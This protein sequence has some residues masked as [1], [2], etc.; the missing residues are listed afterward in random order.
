MDAFDLAEQNQRANALLQ[1]P[2]GRFDLLD[3]TQVNNNPDGRTEVVELPPAVERP[4]PSRMRIVQDARGNVVTQAGG[5]PFEKAEVRAQI[6]EAIRRGQDLTRLLERAREVGAYADQQTPD[7]VAPMREEPKTMVGGQRVGRLAW[8]RLR[9]QYRE[10]YP[11]AAMPVDLLDFDWFRLPP[12]ELQALKDAE[13][14]RVRWFHQY[15]PHYEVLLDPQKV[16]QLRQQF[17]ETYPGQ[18]VP[19]MF[20]GT[21]LEREQAQANAQM[22][23]LRM[24]VRPEFAQ[25]PD[26]A[27]LTAI[28][29]DPGRVLMP[30]QTVERTLLGELA[31]ALAR[32]NSRVFQT[33]LGGGSG[34]LGTAAEALGLKGAGRVLRDAET[35]FQS[36]Y[37]TRG[38]EAESLRPS[39]VATGFNPGSLRWWLA[40][41]GENA[42]QLVYTWGAGAA[43]RAGASSYQLTEKATRILTNATVFGTSAVQ[44]GGAAYNEIRQQLIA[45]GL[46]PETASQ[47]AAIAAAPVAVANGLLELLPFEQIVNNREANRKLFTLARRL[48]HAGGTEGATEVLQELNNIV[49]E[50]GAG[51]DAPTEQAILERLGTAGLIG[52]ALGGGA[53]ATM[54]AAERAPD[55]TAAAVRHGLE[56]GRNVAVEGI[57]GAGA[58]TG[59]VMRGIARA[60]TALRDVE[61]AGR[62]AVAAARPRVQETIENLVSRF[63]RE[64]TYR[65]AQTPGAATAAVDTMDVGA[66]LPP[67]YVPSQPPTAGERARRKALE[68]VRALMDEHAPRDASGRRRFPMAFLEAIQAGQ[69]EARRLLDQFRVEGITG[70]RRAQLIQKLNQIDKAYEVEIAAI[71]A[72]R[73]AQREG[74]PAPE[75]EGIGARRLPP[76]P[77]KLGEPKWK[78]KLS[79][80]TAAKSRAASRLGAG[81]TFGRTQQV[82]TNQILDVGDPNPANVR[83]WQRRLAPGPDSQADAVPPIVVRKLPNGGYQVLDGADQLAAAQFLE[84]DQVPVIVTEGAADPRASAGTAAVRRRITGTPPRRLMRADAAAMK[85]DLVKGVKPG[86]VIHGTDARNLQFIV[87]QGLQASA[88]SGSVD[89]EVVPEGGFGSEHPST[90]AAYAAGR[91]Q[92]LPILIVLD[93]RTNRGAPAQG[94]VNAVTATSPGKS[95]VAPEDIQAVIFPDGQRLPLQEALRYYR[96]TLLPRMQQALPE[97]NEEQPEGPARTQEAAPEESGASAGKS[98]RER[99]D[100]VD[101]SPPI[102]PNLPAEVLQAHGNTDTNAATAADLDELL[103]SVYDGRQLWEMSWSQLKTAGFSARRS[104]DEWVV[105]DPKGLRIMSARSMPGRPV[106]S[107][108]KALEVLREHF[109][110]AARN[111]GLYTPP[112]EKQAL[113]GRAALIETAG[114]EKVTATY[115][116][117]EA[118]D[119]L[120]SHDPVTFRPTPGYPAQLNERDYQNDKEEQAKVNRQV[121]EF[122]PAFVLTDNPDPVNGPPMI[123]AN[124]WV[125]G[126][127]SRA[128]TIQSVYSVRAGANLA[129]SFREQTLEAAGR[130]GIEGGEQMQ[131]PVLVRILDEQTTDVGRLRELVRLLQKGRTQE[132]SGAMDAASRARILLDNPETLERLESLLEDADSIREVMEKPSKVAAIRDWLVNSNV[133]TRAEHARYTNS[134]T[135]MLNEDGKRLIERI[136]QAV[137]VPDPGLFDSLP[138]A[139]ANKITGNLFGL[140]FP[141]T[142][143]AEWDVGPAVTTALKAWYR[144]RASGA[145]LASWIKGEDADGQTLMTRD[146]ILDEPRALKILERLVSDNATA[147]RERVK[148]YLSHAREFRPGEQTFTFAEHTKADPQKAFAEAFEREIPRDFSGNEVSRGKAER[149]GGGLF[150]SGGPEKYYQAIDDLRDSFQWPELMSAALRGALR[151]PRRRRTGFGPV[152][153]ATGGQDGPRPVN[154]ADLLADPATAERLTRIAT[155]H[156]EQQADAADRQTMMIRWADGVRSDVGSILRDLGY[157]VEADGM[158]ELLARL[159]DTL[160]QDADVQDALGELPPFDKERAG[161]SRQRR[162][163]GTGGG[164]GR[165]TRRGGTATDG[166]QPAEG[167]LESD[168]GDGTDAGGTGADVVPP[169]EQPQAGVPGEPDGGDGV[170]EWVPHDQRDAY[171]AALNSDRVSPYVPLEPTRRGHHHPRL[172]VESKA[173]AGVQSGQPGDYSA[174]PRAIGDV[175]DPQRDQAASIGYRIHAGNAGAVIADDVGVGKSRVMGAIIADQMWRAR[176]GL[177]GKQRVLILTKNRQNI[178]DLIKTFTVE[179][180]GTYDPLIQE[181]GLR[182]RSILDLTDAERKRLGE[183]DGGFEIVLLDAYNLS[184]HQEAALAFSPDLVLVD[185]AH[186]FSNLSGDTDRA[187]VLEGLFTRFHMPATHWV[188]LT[189]TPASSIESL[190][191]MYG[192]GLWQPK[193]M[194]ESAEEGDDVRTFDTW[195]QASTGV[196]KAGSW[197]ESIA[198]PIIEQLMRELKMDHAYHSLDFWRGGFEFEMAEA[199]ITSEQFKLYDEAATVLNQAIRLYQFARQAVNHGKWP[200]GPAYSL[201]ELKAPPR[202]DGQAIFFMKRL[203]VEF[204]MARALEAARKAL[205]AGEQ[206]VF[207]ILGVSDTHLTGETGNFGAVF[208]AI[209]TMRAIKNRAG[210]IL[211]WEDIPYGPTTVRNMVDELR[212]QVQYRLGRRSSASPLKMLQDAF[213]EKNIAAI[214]GATSPRDRVAQNA[215]FQAGKRRVAVISSA[216]STGINLQDLGTGRRV[217]IVLDLDWDSKEFKQSLGRVDRANQVSSPRTLTI[218]TP[219][220]GERKFQATIAARMKSLGAISKGQEDAG[221]EQDALN[222]F[223]MESSTW[224]RA[225]NETVRQLPQHV[226]G[227]LLHAGK[228]DDDQELTWRD[229]QNDLMLVPHALG[230]EIY[231]QAY[232]RWKELE[233]LEAERTGGKVARRNRGMIRA[234][235]ALD[236][237]PETALE[238][239]TVEAV[240]GETYGILSGKLLTRPQTATPLVAIQDAIHGKGGSQTLRNHYVTMQQGERIVSGLYVPRSKIERVKALFGKAE[241]RDLFP[242]KGDEDAGAA[243]PLP[244]FVISKLPPAM[245]VMATQPHIPTKVLLRKHQRGRRPISRQDLTNQVIN[246]LRIAVGVRK[247]ARFRVRRGGRILGY[248]WNKLIR[249]HSANEIGV[250]AHEVG[251]AIDDVLTGMKPPTTF[252]QELMP[253]GTQTSR[254]SYT[255]QQVRMEGVAEWFRYYMI[256]PTQAYSLAP[257]Y[258]A[259]FEQE[260]LKY[261]ALWEAV[262]ELQALYAAYFSQDDVAKFESQVDWD[263]DGPTSRSPLAGE[264]IRQYLYRHVVDNRAPLDWMRR[265][266]T[267]DTPLPDKMSQDAYVLSRLKPGIG[268]MVMGWVKFGVQDR[269]GNRLS[270]GLEEV[271][272]E[273]GIRTPR[274]LRKFEAYLLAKRVDELYAQQAAGQRQLRDVIDAYG[275]PLGMTRAQARAVIARYQSPAFDQA[276]RGVWEWNRQF[277]NYLR[278]TGYFDQ[279]QLSL[280]QVMNQQYVPMHRVLD[281]MEAAQGG[282][283]SLVDKGRQFFRIMG[284]GRRVKRPLATMIRNTRRIMEN[285]E[286]NRAALKAFELIQRERDYRWA[287]PISR[288]VA[289]TTG[290]LRE[291]K[292]ALIDAGVDPADFEGHNGQQPK[293]DLDTAFTIF[294][295]IQHNPADMEIAL[296]VNGKIKLWQVHVPAMY[297]ALT[298]TYSGPT[299]NALLRLLMAGKNLARAGFTLFADFM[300][301]NIQRDQITAFT[302][303]RY[304]YNPAIDFW[305]GLNELRKQGDIYRLWLQA[306]GSSSGLISTYTDAL[307]RE[308]RI[309]GK[310]RGRKFLEN[311]FLPWRWLDVLEAVSLTAEQATRLGEFARGLRAEGITEEGLTRAALASRDV[312]VDFWRGGEWSRQ[313]GQWRA[314]FGANVQGLDYTLRHMTGA[315]GSR[316]TRKHAAV[317]FIVR[318]LAGITLP[319][320]ALHLLCRLNPDYQERERERDIYWLI[321]IGNPMT[322]TQWL[323]IRKPHDLGFIFGRAGEDIA[324]YLIT[325][326]PKALEDMIP[327]AQTAADIFVDLL[328]TAIVPWLEIMFNYDTFRERPI[329]PRSMENLEPA[330]QFRRYTSEVSKYLGQKLNVPPVYVDH[331]IYGHTGTLG[332][333][334][335]RGVDALV[336]R[337]LLGIAGNPPPPQGGWE[338]D[339][340]GVRIFFAKDLTPDAAASVAQLYA[341]IEELDRVKRT[342]KALEGDAQR[343]DD[344]RR[345]HVDVLAREDLLRS[346]ERQLRSAR[347]HMRRIYDDQQLTPDQKRDRLRAVMAR[348]VNIARS[349]ESRSLYPEE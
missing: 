287:D 282:G 25:L 20:Q 134:E 251:H 146:P 202:P 135:G 103:K 196:T 169:G 8:E 167:E 309:L 301:S 157:Q 305:I 241:Q 126:G 294:R 298:G 187:N 312:T 30:G 307:E 239:H 288:P 161:D 280:I 3:G 118:A 91:A 78:P 148:A 343:H 86:E 235:V 255:R 194:V 171:L 102:M 73:Q 62:E 90:A 43:A 325:N 121:A 323:R 311:T 199:D 151:L 170:P 52:A 55:W 284:S 346:G 329:I 338:Q 141:R 310:G 180:K 207:K 142:K 322:T 67:D 272:N 190:Q 348:M 27:L 315:G 160:A 203:L 254:G 6:D 71:K 101:R 299:N 286:A 248:Y 231:D 186:L 65:P 197:R 7:P 327:D 274:Q 17:Q 314:F 163:R 262:R 45:S 150:G 330:L 88:L 130:F 14:T 215:E 139:T 211:R 15:G 224:T 337:P 34:L 21:I 168:P 24:R 13:A 326:D 41:V 80:M 2:Q 317:N 345:R 347:D 175:S 268:D 49:A 328:P 94:L 28:G 342:L 192:L 285:V 230:N 152:F 204:R 228:L 54:T 177:A 72:R 159:W 16:A 99:Y 349:I 273:A 165:S 5:D 290:N 107:E 319:T 217:M 210:Q 51:L 29:Q 205:D 48:V 289:P 270:R 253:L 36:Y 234:T 39:D 184:R 195:L 74:R 92:E 108:S 266:L 143:G 252:D 336:M 341:A 60:D 155:F 89:A 95:Y 138:A 185:E 137:V 173:L 320:L 257:L 344:Y 332:M 222:D 295:P 44:E 57:E 292:K 189:A 212:Q 226:K 58:M 105:Y 53:E 243:P 302:Q 339:L 98:V 85:A 191:F 236:E 164:S 61:R 240:T 178:A 188:Y 81:V 23:M 216:G 87:R 77:A 263:D 112:A 149:R 242:K 201:S 140:V 47:R 59:A 279:T 19:E 127:N 82:P 117:V 267:G 229:F 110:E 119:L 281:H 277:I 106:G 97:K 237:S 144:W 321:P 208:N 11:G 221:A 96:D 33:V 249:Q 247:Q 70:D 225:I 278:T 136:L 331:L 340:P 246:R 219:I 223:D 250:L 10:K 42:P 120:P 306:R 84:F 115:A 213:G 296:R 245:Q 220:A 271:L 260:L 244:E 109:E 318:A 297:E 172:L 334:V 79:S 129:R 283:Q 100:F 324:E 214:V 26:E 147:W 335:V 76:P 183:G 145:P 64:V 276:A 269:S 209:P 316:P 333:S 158:T 303:S 131:R 182:I 198:T 304:G 238:I 31:A 308:I 259:W 218:Y 200:V 232:A 275:G 63:R 154:P 313:I 300:A 176:S 111:R 46:D 122:N 233:D 291:I 293:I 132:L 116:L 162:A 32:G 104:G 193:A 50:V 227:Q 114:D 66:E 69:G 124:G 83:L 256:D 93:P 261:P 1:M 75:V 156:L 56:L 206:V 9:Q 153:M 265:E 38:A 18:P 264:S 174:D 123:M 68:R 166:N 125:I 133:L 258:S 179:M 35:N 181:T 4:R 113:R 12:A 40:N 22:Q 37:G 128:M